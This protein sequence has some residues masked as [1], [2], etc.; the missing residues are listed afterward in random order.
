[1][2]ETCGGQFRLWAFNASSLGPPPAPIPPPPPTPI[3]PPDPFLRPIYHTPADNPPGYVGDANGMMYRRVPW[4]AST[5]ENG[6]FHLFWQAQIKHGL[7]WG[8]AVSR[9][10]V[11]VI[12][13]TLLTLSFATATAITLDSFPTITMPHIRIRIYTLLLM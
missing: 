9:D 7:W 10:Y 11:K 12:K 2:H 8:H 1:M 13:L 3:P 5:D 4:D 6:I